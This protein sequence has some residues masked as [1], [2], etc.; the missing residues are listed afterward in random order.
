MFRFHTV[1]QLM[2]IKQAY[3]IVFF[4]ISLSHFNVN[5]PDRRKRRRSI[6][7]V[8]KVDDIPYFQF[9][10]F[11]DH[12]I[13][14]SIPFCCHLIRSFS[15][16]LSWHFETKTKE[17]SMSVTKGCVN[18]RKKDDD[19]KEMPVDPIQWSTDVS[20]LPLTQRVSLPSDLLVRI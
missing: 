3:Q 10:R 15:L 14:S 19:E 4:I 18:N 7:R 2:Q 20:E 12:K 16:S 6:S 11:K 13:N 1:L 5:T 17:L 9:I 8:S